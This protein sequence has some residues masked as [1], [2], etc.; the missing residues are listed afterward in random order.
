MEEFLEENNVKGDYNRISNRWMSFE[1]LGKNITSKFE[2]DKF[3]VEHNIGKNEI[4]IIKNAAFNL[5][6]IKETSELGV[7][8]NRFLIRQLPKW[9]KSQKKMY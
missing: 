9:I 8:D 5:I 2:N 7:G 1:E 4:G 6:K 3:L